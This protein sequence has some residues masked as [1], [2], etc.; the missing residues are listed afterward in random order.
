MMPTMPPFPT[1]PALPPPPPSEPPPPPQMMNNCSAENQQSAVAFTNVNVY[2]GG[3][4]GGCGSWPYAQSALPAVYPTRAA[5][6]AQPSRT[7]L[8]PQ[9][10]PSCGVTQTSASRLTGGSSP[11]APS[12]AASRSV[13]QGVRSMTQ[14]VV[15]ER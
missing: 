11:A 6:S 2:G 12:T 14:P 5:I 8:T 3:A 1:P 10:V 4:A 15:T 7:T 9:P 13:F